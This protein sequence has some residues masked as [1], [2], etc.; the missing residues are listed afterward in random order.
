MTIPSQD[1]TASVSGTAGGGFAS[2]GPSRQTVPRFFTVLQQEMLLQVPVNGDSALL[3]LPSVAEKVTLPGRVNADN[4]SHAPMPAESNNTDGDLAQ[5]V[6]QPAPLAV[7]DGLSILAQF[8]TGSDGSL[9]SLQYRSRLQTAEATATGLVTEEKKS[10]QKTAGHKKAETV[11]PEDFQTQIMNCVLPQS[12][13]GEKVDI[14]PLNCPQSPNGSGAA[15]Q[16]SE[17]GP[18][19]DPVDNRP[20]LNN[21]VLDSKGA[22][23][24]QTSSWPVSA[25]GTESKALAAAP[26]YMAIPERA[27]ERAL[28]SVRT[29]TADYCGKDNLTS[30]LPRQD[31]VGQTLW[32]GDIAPV[33]AGE[34]VH[35]LAMPYSGGQGSDMIMQ[36][37]PVVNEVELLPPASAP[38]AANKPNVVS[39]QVAAAP[40][41]NGSLANLSSPTVEYSAL[42]FK[43][44]VSEAEVLP[45]ALT[46]FAASKLNFALPQVAAA[47][48]PNGL[49]AHSSSAKVD[50]NALFGPGPAAN[51]VSETLPVDVANGAADSQDTPLAEA[52]FTNL[53]TSGR[54]YGRAEPEAKSKVKKSSDDPGLT[55]VRI[56]DAPGSNRFE[57]HPKAEE[58][59]NTLH[60]SILAQVKASVVS[61]DG[62]GNGVMTVRLNPLE[63]G[64]LQIKVRLENQQVKVEIISDNR[65]VREALMGNLDNL[66]ESLLKQNL[67]MERFDVS[68]G[69]GNGFSQGFREERGAQKRISSLLYGQETLPA[70]I[71][72][73]NGK[74]DWGVT[75]NS[76]VNLRF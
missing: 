56:I 18:G 39:P 42:Q 20:G 63:L 37:K 31:A 2:T 50:Y 52:V 13:F 65:T 29:Q 48:E 70:E 74:D 19:T 14:P 33:Q 46:P 55:A 61:H 57:L 45:P 6:G 22:A 62:K 7:M 26:G 34:A 1:G 5:D 10:I 64:D 51:A 23:S 73:E 35:L 30:L 53:S 25:G 72:P 66:K 41:P 4:S 15:G 75:E 38:F 58:A 21:S 12:A 11:G 28:L 76:L 69:G 49:L 32:T 36:F 27:A 24:A 47:A 44:V 3:A 71:I 40:E 54:S 59:K 67:N 9:L 43:P 68:T 8:N 17:A 60:E 16:P